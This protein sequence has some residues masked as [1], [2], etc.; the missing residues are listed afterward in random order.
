MHQ[1]HPLSYAGQR[2][3]VDS[4]GINRSE[5]AVSV[6][7]VSPA[8]MTTR[9]RGILVAVANPEGVVPL[10]AIAL[11]ASDPNEEPP[12]RVLALIRQRDAAAGAGTTA[13]QDQTLAA[14]PALT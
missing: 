4:G 8:M 10:M 13:A 7:E 3:P 6:G 11:A 14:P 12:P 1:P 9:R 2:A 5:G